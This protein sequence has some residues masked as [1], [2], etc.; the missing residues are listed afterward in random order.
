MSGFGVTLTFLWGSFFSNIPESPRCNFSLCVLQSSEYRSVPGTTGNSHKI[1]SWQRKQNLFIF[2]TSPTRKPE[3]PFVWW[4]LFST[5][6]HWDG[7]PSM[8]WHSVTPLNWSWQPKLERIPTRTSTDI[9]TD[10]ISVHLNGLRIY[11]PPHSSLHLYHPEKKNKGIFHQI[12]KTHGT[13]IC[14]STGV[15]LLLLIVSILVQV[16]QPRKKVTESYRL[17]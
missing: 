13:I 3:W 14:V 6:V 15:V 1:S 8:P 12:T 9:M 10:I 7:C 4:K 2:G 17:P 5:L 16:K 11:I